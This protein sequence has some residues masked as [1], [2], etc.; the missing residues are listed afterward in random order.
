MGNPKFVL[1]GTTSQKPALKRL[2]EGDC[3]A[4]IID[5]P[6]AEAV[7]FL[8]K[9]RGLRT[10]FLTL[11]I[12]VDDAAQDLKAIR[13]GAAG[14]LVRESLTVQSLE[15]E[16]LL[17]TNRIGADQ[18]FQAPSKKSEERYRRIVDE[19]NEIIY[20]ISPEG[21]FT[22][23]NPT[24][25]AV[26]QRTVEEC[27]NLHFLSL[28]RKDYV[29]AAA[30]FYREQIS[31]KHP[32][33]Y[34][35]FPAVAGDGSEV[36]I[37]QNV[38]LVI[39]KGEV[40][41]L[42]G[43]GRDITARKKIEQQLL[44]SEQRYRLLFESNPHP[45][46]VFDI[47]TLLFLT[48]NNA[49][50]QNYGYSLEDFLSMTIMDIRPPEEMKRLSDHLPNGESGTLPERWKHMKKDGSV[51]DVEITK[52]P[53]IFDGKNAEL[54]TATDITARLR[55]ECERQAILDIT[56]SV[57]VTTNLDEL[58]TFIHQSLKRILYAENCFV[59]FHDQAT[60][61]IQ[62]KYWIDKFDPVPAPQPI[63]DGFTS[64]VLRT[65]R[66]LSLTGEFKERMHSVSGVR[67]SGSSSASWL[68]VPL[69]TPSRTIGVLVVQHYETEQA[70]TQH[71]IDFLSSVGGQIAL[72][73]ERKRSEDS[74]SGS[75]PAGH[76]RL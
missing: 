9:A 6:L 7:V 69:R 66:A 59:A 71:D 53:L 63:G 64:H 38:Q 50:I 4:C 54:I 14:C 74:P 20:R 30:K 28:V 36:W 68:G 16:L 37:G 70:Y 61:L 21:R 13:A 55:A 24:A 76:H 60:D 31:K 72:A 73:I 67:M 40:V 26:V 51:I 3:D 19:A 65:G 11:L 29:G 35:E 47:E 56:R 52:F 42:Q 8:G 23:V 45:M 18:A 22:F 12:I 39:E 44:D 75:Q 41:E 48:V 58:L 1:A 57:N 46:W 27:L 43:L 2:A 10:P 15:R 34:F 5:L 62:F 49:A 33:S 17:L 32:L 25:A